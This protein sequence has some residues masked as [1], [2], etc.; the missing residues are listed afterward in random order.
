MKDVFLNNVLI[1]TLIV[2]TN[3]SNLIETDLQLTAQ[4]TI[5]GIHI[6]TND[7]QHL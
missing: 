5:H 2:K 7:C 6:G 1:H 3:H 4:P